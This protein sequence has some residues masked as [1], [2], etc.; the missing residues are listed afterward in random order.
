[1]STWTS[2][3]RA[4]LLL[5]AAG[6]LLAACFETVS[7]NRAASRASSESSGPAETAVLD[8]ALT[9]TGPAGYC[10]DPEATRE[11][12][13]EAF[14]L[15]VR[16]SATARNAPVLSATVTAIDAPAGS[17]PETLRRLAAF[18]GSDLGRAQLS[19]TGR[20]ADVRIDQTLVEGGVLWLRIHDRGNPAAFDPAYWRAILPIAERVVTLSVLSARANPVGRERELLVLRD[21][22]SRM[23][24]RNP[25]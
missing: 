12:D 22:V 17:D 2:K 8:G 9:V 23:R 18:V 24:A 16:C 20:P 4:F 25:G 6:L 1:M 19:R 11:S 3:A 15:L 21:F 14:V 7:L 13:T 10:V 5:G